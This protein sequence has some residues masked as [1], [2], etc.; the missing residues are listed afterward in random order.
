MKMSVEAL[1]KSIKTKMNDLEGDGAPL[2]RKGGGVYF[3]STKANGVEYIKV[4]WSVDPPSRLKVLQTGCPI[5]MRL[6]AVLPSGDTEEECRMHE[7]LS[8]YHHRGE[9][10]IITESELRSVV[11]FVFT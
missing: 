5:E 10:F 2:Y 4:G 7:I 8:D 11:P 6:I 3:I 1:K 9:W